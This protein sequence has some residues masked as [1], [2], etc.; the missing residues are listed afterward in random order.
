MITIDQLRR[1]QEQ[2]QLLALES[3]KESKKH[4]ENVRAIVEAR[5]REFLE[6]SEDIQRRIE[7]LDL[8]SGMARELD[9]EVPLAERRLKVVGNQP[10]EGDVPLI[11]KK[12]LAAMDRVL[13]GE[14]SQRNQAA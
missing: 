9:D 7:A 1:Q 8:V 10:M 5:E 13:G 11:A 2:R 14:S 3:L 12:A 4:L 6:A